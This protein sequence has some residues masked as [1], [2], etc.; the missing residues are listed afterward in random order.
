MSA[1]RRLVGRAGPVLLVVAGALVLGGLL[2]RAP[3]TQSIRLMLGEGARTTRAVRVRYENGSGELE[4]EA[5]LQFAPGAAPRVLA[6]EP[7]LADGAYT[8]QIEVEREEGRALVERRVTLSGGTLQVPLD[9][10]NE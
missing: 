7:T 4:R 5:Q 9:A 2:D 6:L 8:L 1:A 10:P 3:K